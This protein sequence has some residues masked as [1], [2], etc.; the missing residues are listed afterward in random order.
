VKDQG[1]WQPV[2]RGNWLPEGNEQLSIIFTIIEKYEEMMK[3][4]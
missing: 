3:E 4:I 2:G 1:G